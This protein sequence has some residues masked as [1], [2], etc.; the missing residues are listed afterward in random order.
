MSHNWLQTPVCMA[1]NETKRIEV[2][3]AQ[4]SNLVTCTS[5]LSNLCINIQPG[6]HVVLGCSSAPVMIMCRQQSRL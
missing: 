3:S 4:I 5:E 6:S 1:L 2:K